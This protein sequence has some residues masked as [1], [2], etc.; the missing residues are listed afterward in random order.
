[1]AEAPVQ[2]H[3]FKARA[4]LAARRFNAW[5][6]GYAFDEALERADLADRFGAEAIAGDAPVNLSE[7]LWG[8]GRVEPGDPAW[9]MRHARALGLPLK[10]KVLVFGAALGAPLRD[11]RSGTRWK[12]VGFTHT[13]ARAP[14]LDLTAYDAAMTR[15]ARAEGDGAITLFELARETD[16]GAFARFVGE[17]LHAG[18]PAV[19]V[20]Y[21][22]A[23]R[24]SR[25]RTCFG[26]LSPGAP[27][28]SGEYGA[29]IK[30]AGFIV[31][32]TIDETRSFMPLI[33][34]GWANWRRAYEATRAIA[35]A[36]ARADKLLAIKQYA[37]LWAERLDA[38]KSGQLQV[39]RI[40]ARKGG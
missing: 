27:K 5:W 38:L 12:T 19:F 3:S 15:I 21:A 31:S 18:A 13:P 34:K 11:L 7:L 36:R 8:A 29:A 20:D 14:G 1:M 4:A 40:Q 25:L 22:V 16:V 10:A 26:P 28:T 39:V 17:H 37:D 2:F 6:E 30:E 24:G 33:A 35:D 32:D 23:R 9:T